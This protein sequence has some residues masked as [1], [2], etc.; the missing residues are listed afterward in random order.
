MF[1]KFLFDISL[2]LFYYFLL[3][4]Y[5]FI[6]IYLLYIFFILTF[7]YH[8]FIN[9]RVNMEIK[10][11]QLTFLLQR[12]WLNLV[13]Y[14]REVVIQLSFLNPRRVLQI[15]AALWFLI[16]AIIQNVLFCPRFTVLRNFHSDFIF[17][18]YS[19]FLWKTNKYVYKKHT[20]HTSS[21]YLHNRQSAWPRLVLQVLKA[22]TY[23]CGW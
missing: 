8:Y 16:P 12:R 19:Y 20:Y 7:L 5:L 11:W 10:L 18:I 13:V 3:L 2:I 4:Y 6:F 14:L 15:W 1:N 22:I 17:I 9:Y 21:S 23:A